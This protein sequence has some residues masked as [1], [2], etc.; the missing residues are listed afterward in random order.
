MKEIWKVIEG[1]EG[2]YEV[3]NLGNIKSN[4]G[5]SKLLKGG[6]DRGYRYVDFQYKGIYKRYQVHRL[7]AT[8][9]LPN[10]NNLPEVNHK[11]ENKLNNSVDNLE[12][13]SKKYNLNY[14]SRNSNISNSLKGRK[15]SDSHKKS[16]SNSIKH[17]WDEGSYNKRRR[18]V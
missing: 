18:N 15:L 7:V 12:W 16:I 14:G 8:Y 5:H 2:K 3:S 1:F 11:D 13:C 9:F 4:H 10:P 6:I 17:L